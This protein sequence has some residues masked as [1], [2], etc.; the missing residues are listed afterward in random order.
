M[1]CYF[2]LVML[3]NTVK[4]VKANPI[5]ELK[6]LRFKEIGFVASTFAEGE[7]LNNLQPKDLILMAH[8]GSKWVKM[9]TRNVITYEEIRG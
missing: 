9:I 8:R 2:L 6:V 3:C 5:S 1:C 7:L 4:V